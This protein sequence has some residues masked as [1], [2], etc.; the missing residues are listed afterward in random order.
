[1]NGSWGAHLLLGFSPCLG[2][3]QVMGLFFSGMLAE[4][5]KL[6][7]LRDESDVTIIMSLLMFY[8]SAPVII[9]R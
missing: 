7:T 6:N 9:F 8:Y 1:M 4:L 3:S 2:R 5:H